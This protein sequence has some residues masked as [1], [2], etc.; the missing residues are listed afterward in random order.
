MTL[1]FSGTI[2][3]PMQVRDGW[4]E[5]GLV[6][7]QRSEDT[8]LGMPFFTTHNCSLDFAGSVLLVDGKALTCTDRHWRMLMNSVWMTREVGI[9]SETEATLLCRVT[10]RNYSSLGLIKGHSEHLPVATNLN[11]PQENSKMNTR[12]MKLALILLW[13]MSGYRSCTQ[14]LFHATK[15]SCQ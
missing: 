4:A 11:R 15:E 7:S 5:V 12:C 9:P 13:M 1:P 8:I 2:R 14:T 6:V 10:I 3:F